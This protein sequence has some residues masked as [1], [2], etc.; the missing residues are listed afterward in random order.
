MEVPA[1]RHMTNF[2]ENDILNYFYGFFVDFQ[3]FVKNSWKPDYWTVE[4]L[5]K[6]CKKEIRMKKLVRRKNGK[7]QNGL[8]G[9]WLVLFGSFRPRSEGLMLVSHESG[10]GWINLDLGWFVRTKICSCVPGSVRS[11]PAVGQFS[12]PTIKNFRRYFWWIYSLWE[13]R[14]FCCL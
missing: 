10:S 6:K 5:E 7:F 11:G 13:K 9:V 1:N 12:I 4:G 3:R 2:T 14:V 8:V